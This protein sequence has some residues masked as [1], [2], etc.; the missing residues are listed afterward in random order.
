MFALIVILLLTFIVR[1]EKAIDRDTKDGYSNC[2]YWFYDDKIDIEALAKTGFSKLTVKYSDIDKTVE[3]DEYFFVFVKNVIYAINKQELGNDIETVALLIKAPTIGGAGNVT[4]YKTHSRIR[5]SL[6][7]MFILS[8]LSIYIALI[9]TVI[10]IGASPLPDF[11]FTMVE[12]MWIFYLVIPIPLASA[13]LGMVYLG[14]KYKCK[15]NIV[16]GFI[17]CAVLAIYGSFTFAFKNETK[18]DFAKVTSIESAVRLDLPDSGYVSYHT[19]GSG[20]KLQTKGMIKFDDQNGI[21]NTVRNCNH[22][23]TDASSFEN[24]V[25]SYNRTE[26]KNYDYFL[27]YDVTCLIYN[28]INVLREHIGHH[29][30]YLAY[31]ADK[32][33]L[34]FAEFIYGS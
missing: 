34:Y 21:L 28:D 4:P 13:I 1:N 16:A 26:T 10:A 30:V 29:F 20:T 8:L 6:L 24:V 23:I 31:S 18:H 27:L 7:A 15:K 11:D 14:K 22:F 5:R 9:A 17:M 19:S 2:K 33:V 32:N 12:Y 25:S 3:R